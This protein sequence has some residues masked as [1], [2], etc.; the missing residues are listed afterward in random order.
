MYVSS[1]DYKNLLAFKKEFN[2]TNFEFDKYSELSYMLDFITKNAAS[3]SLDLHMQINNEIEDLFAK[4]TSADCKNLEFLFFTNV[5]NEL[6]DRDLLGV[7]NSLASVVNYSNSSKLFKNTSHF[8]K[9]YS[10]ILS[11]IF[12][13]ISASPK[14]VIDFFDLSIFWEGK[15]IFD[16]V[17]VDECSQLSA[18]YLPI[19]HAL[20]NKL[21]LF[22]DDKQ[23][24][25]RA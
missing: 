14:S 5:L 18:S 22:G 15:Y 10:S 20:S 4:K 11:V 25:P 17:F 13:I 1:A 9:M 23:L 24:S 21:Y 6:I 3:I 19:L 2:P 7:L 12:R 8:L 16:S